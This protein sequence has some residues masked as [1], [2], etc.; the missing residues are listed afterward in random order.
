MLAR[1][2]SDQELAL[3]IGFIQADRSL[4][5]NVDPNGESR[6]AW[7]FGFGQYDEATKSVIFKELPHYTGT[8]WQG[9][10]QMPD[11]ALAYTSLDASGGHPGRNAAH[12]TILRWTAP[13]AGVVAIEGVI[14][15]PSDQG[16]GVRANVISSRLGLQ[17]TW[18]AQHG[19]ATT[20]VPN[21]AVLAGDTI[22]FVVDCRESD[23]NDAYQ[24]KPKIR[25]KNA[26]DNGLEKDFAWN[27][28][29]EFAKASQS[30][31]PAPKIDPWVE[32]SQVLLLSNEFTFV[33]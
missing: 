20:A 14:K 8:S 30:Q 21:V 6:P 2:P 17:G 5:Q 24:W 26:T 11:A 29:R 4:D 18:L 3:A 19:E 7:R 25:V 28:T 27:A 9:S 1:D 10:A 33:D 22:D 31:L 32:L 23:A 12:S 15:H 13:G 16:D